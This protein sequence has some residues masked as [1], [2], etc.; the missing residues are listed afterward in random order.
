MWTRGSSALSQEAKNTLSCTSHEKFHTIVLK[1]TQQNFVIRS[2]QCIFR[3]LS[4]II[5]DEVD[6]ITLRKRT[7]GA[8]I[9][10]E[11]HC[12]VAQQTPSKILP[13]KAP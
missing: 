8:K 3:R 1:K 12:F 10:A 13:W 5:L 2:I 7:K 11:W 9:E 6:N 4:L